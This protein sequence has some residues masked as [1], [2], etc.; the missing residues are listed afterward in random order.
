M[1]ENTKATK[2]LKDFG[3]D[4]REVIGVKV[5]VSKKTGN[6]YYTYHCM[7]NFTNYDVENAEILSMLT[8]T[9]TTEEYT[10]LRI[11]YNQKGENKHNR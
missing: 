11:H 7:A 4:A 3:E 6:K 9:Y 8:H 2:M 5:T 10:T 1:S